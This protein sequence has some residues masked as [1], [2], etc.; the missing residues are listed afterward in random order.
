MCRGFRILG[1]GL[2]YGVYNDIEFE[3]GNILIYMD[4]F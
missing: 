1:F 3:L 2:E 4:S